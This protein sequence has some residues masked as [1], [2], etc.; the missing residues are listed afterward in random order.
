MSAEDEEFIGFLRRYRNRLLVAVNKTEGGRREADAWNLLSYGFDKVYMISAEHVDNIGELEEAIL[1]R[2]DFS[3]V[4][5]AG[6]ADSIA[7]AG[8]AN[9]IADDGFID[10]NDIRPIRIALLGKPNT[11]KSTLS[12]R[13][14]ASSASI[15]SDIPGTTRDVVEG[16]FSWKNRDFQV[17]DTAGIRR[18]TKVTEN[19]EYYSVNRA[20]KTIDDA[21]IV[22]LMIDAVEGLSEQDKK[23]AGLAHDKGRGI[24]MV[25]NKWDTMPQIKNAFEAASDRIHFLFGKMEYAPIVAV[26]ACDGT[27]VDKLLNTAMRM[28]KQL[29][30]KIETG[31]LNQALERWLAENPPPMGP[32]TR[33]KIKYAVQ[34]SANPAVFIFFASRPRAVSEAYT[35]YLRNKIRKDLGFSL[36]PVAVEIRSSAG[37][38]GKNRKDGMGRQNATG[39]SRHGQKG[40]SVQS[41]S[42]RKTSPRRKKG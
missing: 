4:K 28:Y 19:I 27:G 9:V 35:A 42:V 36:V 31:P 18:K 29:Q 10:E 14:T 23:I 2:L 7:E 33:F 5:K 41:S 34:K 40:A 30:I 15:V 11:G 38:A 16:V 22:F 39:K 25:L 21:D 24:I 6:K 8:I 37:E 12:N 1:S 13:L 20:I 3:K 26:S 17:L 32:Q